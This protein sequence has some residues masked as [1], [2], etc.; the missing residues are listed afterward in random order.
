MR[1]ETKRLAVN[2]RKQRIQ[3]LVE[4]TEKLCLENKLLKT[5]LKGK[6]LQDEQITILKEENLKLREQLSNIKNC[7]E[8]KDKEITKLKTDVE[9]LRARKTV[10]IKQWIDRAFVKETIKNTEQDL[11]KEKKSE[12]VEHSAKMSWNFDV[13]KAISKAKFELAQLLELEDVDVL[14]EARFTKLRIVHKDKVFELIDALKLYKEKI[15]ALEDDILMFNEYFQLEKQTHNGLRNFVKDMK[16]EKIQ[17]C[18]KF[19]NMIKQ[20][21]NMRTKYEFERDAHCRLKVLVETFQKKNL[22]VVLQLLKKEKPLEIDIKN[23]EFKTN[24]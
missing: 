21:E 5:H 23:F 18:Q 13:S 20:N 14:D 3:E 4:L 16:M 19:E 10:S 22:E 8:A 2:P 9:T 12:K 1:G 17:L 6:T 15:K 7:R 24:H 11:V